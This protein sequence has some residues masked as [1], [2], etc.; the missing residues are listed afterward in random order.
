MNALAL[1]LGILLFS[2][3]ITSAEIIPFINLLYFFK[4]KRLKQET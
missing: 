3:L 4:F 1:P 2:F